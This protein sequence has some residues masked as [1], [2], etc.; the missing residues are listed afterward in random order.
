MSTMRPATGDRHPA[1][2]RLRVRDQVMHRVHVPVGRLD[3]R[4][5]VDHL[6]AGEATEARRHPA[7]DPLS[8]G[9]ARRIVSTA[10]VVQQRGVPQNLA[11]EIGPFPLVLDRDHDVAAIRAGKG[12]V[13]C[14]GRMLET[15][16]LGGSAAES[17]WHRVR[18][19]G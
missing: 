11:A 1:G 16:T 7:V 4:Q 9:A 15:D 10:R 17:N 8:V 13:G 2:A 6:G 3:R 12:A 18:G 14:D 5:A 19:S